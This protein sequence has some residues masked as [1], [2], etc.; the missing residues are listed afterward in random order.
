MKANTDHEEMIAECTR[1]LR[2]ANEFLASYSTDEL[3]DMATRIA[4]IG[5][6]HGASQITDATKLANAM[7]FAEILSR[8]GNSNG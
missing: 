1:Q 4:I 7:I 2:D 5:I 8:E 3:V 6:S